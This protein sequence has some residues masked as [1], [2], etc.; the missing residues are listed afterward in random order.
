MAE[1]EKIVEM[2]DERANAGNVCVRHESQ[3]ER[4]G[5]LGGRR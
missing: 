1:R 3:C 2:N 5:Y 4:S